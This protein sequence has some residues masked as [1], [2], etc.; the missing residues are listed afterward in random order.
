VGDE[1]EQ[2]DRHQGEQADGDADGWRR[3]D[4]R[5]GLWIRIERWIERYLITG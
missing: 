4:G 1:L 3:D 2:A 5:F